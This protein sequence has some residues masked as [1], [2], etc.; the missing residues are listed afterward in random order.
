MSCVGPLG[1]VATA[2]EA[3][4][5]PSARLRAAA[6]VRLRSLALVYGGMLLLY[7]LAVAR[8]QPMVG[9]GSLCCF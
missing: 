2:L 5:L 6:A 9:R 1:E 8:A 7:L 4:R 3:R